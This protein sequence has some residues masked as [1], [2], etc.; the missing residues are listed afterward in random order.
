MSGLLIA[1]IIICF[2]LLALIAT[3]IWLAIRIGNKFHEEE[4]SIAEDFH[5]WLQQVRKAYERGEQVN[6]NRK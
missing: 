2:I 4:G 6:D 1:F 5:A 3:G